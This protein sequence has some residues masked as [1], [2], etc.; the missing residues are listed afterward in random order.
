MDELDKV[1]NRAGRADEPVGEDDL[2]LVVPAVEA[3]CRGG[4][5]YALDH[6]RPDAFDRAADAAGR[7]GSEELSRALHAAAE[8]GRN[9]PGFNLDRAVT[10]FDDQ[11]SPESLYGSLRG[12]VAHRR[13]RSP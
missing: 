11:H 1:I 9:H 10:D 13:E 4:L 6:L 5:S 7:L 2:R 3:L 8:I 12:V